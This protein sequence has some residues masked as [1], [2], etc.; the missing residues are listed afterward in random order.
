M[1]NKE[2]DAKV[3]AAWKAKSKTSLWVWSF[4]LVILSAGQSKNEVLSMPVAMIFLLLFYYAI[5]DRISYWR[6]KHKITKEVK[7]C[8]Q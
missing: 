4:I 5:M 7:Q 3:K 8:Q 6:L 1:E 2:I